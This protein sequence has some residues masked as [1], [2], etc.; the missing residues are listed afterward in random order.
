M[1][2]GRRQQQ[3]RLRTLISA[4][5]I[6]ERGNENKKIE[7]IF[8]VSFSYAIWIMIIISPPHRFCCLH[9]PRWQQQQ[10]SL[11]SQ[12]I[13][14]LELRPFLRP[15]PSSDSEPTFTRGKQVLHGH[16]TDHDAPSL[17]SYH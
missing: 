5:Y 14:T 13:F 4:E 16:H 9:I 7:F 17:A 2:C 10:S 6:A 3:Q 15:S 8:S 12:A 11:H 1:I